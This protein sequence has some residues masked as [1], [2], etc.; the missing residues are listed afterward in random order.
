MFKQTYRP[1]FERFGQ[2]G[3]TGV[4]EGFVRNRPSLLPLQPFL[5][6]QNPHQLGD[7]DDRVGVIELNGNLIGEGVPGVI[8]QMKTAN[9]VAQRT[10]AEEVLLLEPQLLALGCL[11]VRIKHLTDIFSIGFHFDGTHI[12]AGIKKLEIELVGGPCAPQTQNINRR[13][14]VTG[15][16]RGVRFAKHMHPRVPARALAALFVGVAFGAP[17][18]AN[19]D[20]II[21]ARKLPGRTVE[22]PLVGFLDLTPINEGLFENPELV[23]NPI[24]DRRD[25]HCRQRVDEAGGEPPQAAV[26]EAGFDIKLKQ[27]IEVVP[28]G[29]EDLADQFGGV[30]VEQILG[31][32]FAEHIFGREIVDELGISL[33]M[34]VSGL[35]A[36][37][38]QQ[39]THDERKGGVDAALTG[40]LNGG[41]E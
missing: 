4:G 23:A 32:L 24:A 37:G 22:K 30:C 1:A 5:I 33:V 3:V 21:G 25:V 10:C 8:S 7:G 13:R 12:V 28:V 26:A 29:G 40:G 41:T 20:H 39:V 11:V 2:E 18:Q 31:Q 35:A 16:Q 36:A 15:H 19:F 34:G 38:H 17:V 27:F 6:K 9:N 14:A